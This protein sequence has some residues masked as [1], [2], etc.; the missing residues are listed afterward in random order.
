MKL[1]FT[2]AGHAVVQDGKPVYVSDAGADVV[3]DYPGTIA[4][5]ARLNG[6]AKGH[7][8]RAEAAE[9][10]VKLFDGI[11][12]PEAARKAITTVRNFDD[13]KLVDAGEV[14]RVKSEAMKAV[15]EKYRPVVKERDSLKASLFQE[16]IG[17]SFARSKFIADKLA[18]PPDIAEAAFGRAF[19]VEDGRL[20]ATDPAGNRIYSRSR[21]GELA[22]FDEAMESLVAAY[23]NRDSILKGTGASGGGASGNSGGG[24]AKTM[25][26]AAFDALPPAAQSAHVKSGGTVVA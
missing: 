11:D 4:T 18:I 15:E 8:E 17:G 6:E 19:A 24:G 12:D 14:E 10:R 9:G 26:R 3:F 22:D 16:K 25:G 7:R 5:I 13:K 2:E 20:V 1:K 23:P 21:P